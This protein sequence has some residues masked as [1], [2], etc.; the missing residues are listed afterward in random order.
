MKIFTGTVVSNK[1]QKTSTVAVTRM[2]AHP[3][4]KKRVKKTRKYQVHD[5]IGHKVGDTVMFTACAPLSKSKKW[6]IY[7]GSKTKAVKASA[8]AKAEK[9]KKV[10]V[11]VEKKVTKKAQPKSK[12]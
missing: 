11:K 2:V 4:Y 1:M 6:A 9:V 7:D 3:V 10:A 5:E 12:K 8:P